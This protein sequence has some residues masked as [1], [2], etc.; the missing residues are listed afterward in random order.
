MGLQT[1]NIVLEKKS[2]IT[3][4]RMFSLEHDFQRIQETLRR[5][6]I[7][8]HDADSKLREKLTEFESVVDECLKKSCCCLIL[9]PSMK[10]SIQTPSVTLSSR[11]HLHW[12]YRY[13]KNLTTRFRRRRKL[14]KVIFK[15]GENIIKP[16]NRM[17]FKWI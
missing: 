17:M 12:K 5:K 4:N 11:Q 8:T 2:S 14:G 1:E 9:A 15:P 13:R 6:I 3:I 16:C 7:D 10:R